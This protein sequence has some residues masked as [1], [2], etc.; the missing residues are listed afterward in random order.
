MDASDILASVDILDYI[1]QY[2]DFEERGGEYWCLSPFT[3]EKTPS[4][5][6]NEDKQYFYDFSSGKGGNVVDF[7]MAYHKVSLRQAFDLLK[8]FAGIKESQQ[9]E[10]SRLNATKIARRFSRLRKAKPPP[11]VKPM[12]EDYMNRFEFRK[13]KLQLWADEGISWDVMRQ[14]GVRYDAV[15]DRIVFPLRDY[16]GRIVAIRG[17]TCDPDYKAKG[18]RKYT[19][20]N[21]IGVSDAIYGYA[22][23]AEAIAAQREIILFEGEKS[24]LIMRTWGFQNAGALLTSHLNEHQMKF[25]IRLGA[26]VVFALDKEI[27]PQDDPNIRQ[28]SHFVPVDYIFDAGNL[29]SEKMAPVDAGLSVWQGLYQSRRHLL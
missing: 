27:R 9:G 21:Q 13:D 6:I 3:D 4:F 17:R 7:I 10:V 19:Y 15:T 18:I 14:A 28:L 25:L 1:S 20:L 2:C 16:D 23:G 5:S 12:P 11:A 29:L 22:E 26:R 8:K 24:V